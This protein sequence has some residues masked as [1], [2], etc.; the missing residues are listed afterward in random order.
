MDQTKKHIKVSPE[1][2]ANVFS[3]IFY[4][5]FL[6][7]YYFGYKNDIQLKDIYNASKSDHSEM[8]GDKLQMNWE[9]E[10]KKNKPNLKRAIF[11]TFVKPYSL[12]G[13]VLFFQY[14][15]MKATS[16]IIV[17]FIIVVCS[18]G[19]SLS[20]Q[21]VGMRARVAVCSLMYRKVLKLNHKSLGQT[22][23]GQVVN[24][25][26]NDVQRFDLVSLFLHYMW[27]TPINVLVSFYV[28][29]QS[30]GIVAAAAGMGAIILE[31]IPIQAFLSNLQG[32]FRYQ[33]AIKTDRR[34]KLMNEITSGIQVIK[35]YAW[36]KPFEKMV[37]LSRKLE[38]NYIRKSS[39]IFGMI[40]SMA[41]FAER[42]CLYVT[43]MTVVLLGKSIRGDV[44]FSIAQLFNT[45]KLTI[46]INLPWCLSYYADAKVSLARIEK[47]LLLEEVDAEK[48]I[49]SEGEVGEVKLNG[50]TASWK[51]DSIAPTLIDLTFRIEPGTLCCVVGNVGAG[52]SSILQ[53]LLRELTVKSGT[54]TTN[55]RIAFASQEPWLFVSS[56]RNNI[57][58][59]K[60]YDRERYR[61][62]VKVC[63]LIKDFQQ[64]PFGDKTLVGERG[65][66]LS[67]GQRARVNLARAVYSE[68]DIYLFDDP[69]SAVDTKVARHLF[70]ECFI[71]YLSGKTR[72]LVTHQLQFMKQADL[73][74][75]GRIEKIG[76]FDQLS[77]KDLNII[78][79][80]AE[81]NGKNELIKTEGKEKIDEVEIDT[82][83]HDPF[84][85]NIS[86][87]SKFGDETQ[88]KD[89]LIEKGVIKTKTYMAYWKDGGGWFFLLFTLS[90]FII[91]QIASNAADLW[92]TNWT[93][94]EKERIRIFEKNITSS[95]RTFNGTVNHTLDATNLPDVDIKPKEY[96]MWIYTI[97]IFSSVI[98]L[99]L[100][101]FLYYIIC[102]KASKVLHNKM[103]TNVLRAPMRF[104]D[105]NPSGRILSRFS[106]D[107]GAMDE[108][109][110]RS[111]IEAIQ[112]FLLL[113]GILAMVFSVIPWMVIPTIVLGTVFYWFRV[114]YLK[115]AQG[116]KR[117]EGT[118]KA[119]VFSHLSATLCGIPTIRSAN[120]QQMVTKEFDVLQN[121]HT[122]TWFLFLISSVSFGFYL[123]MISITFLA[124]LTYQFVLFNNGQF[125][126]GNIGLV[127]SQSLILTGM[128]Q[129]GV[130]QSA[131][132][133][134][135]MIS[136]ERI[137]QYTKL[138][139]EGPFETVGNKPPR[140]WP[141]KGRITFKNTCLRYAM[142]L[143]PV[144]K[145]IN[146]CIEPS[147][148]VGIV[149]RTGAGKS[150]LISSI[151]RLAPIDG[152][153]C[154]DDVDTSKIGLN[155]L[156]S[157]ISIIP[158]EPVLFSA[159]LRYNLDPF[160]RHSDEDLWNALEYVELKSAFPDLNV[161]ISE[162][163]SNL[164][165]GQRQ[166]IC[167]ARAIV[168]NN[169]VLV[170]DEATANVDPQ[171]DA[172]IQKTI[173]E[174]FKDCTVLTIAHRLN[175]IM[176]SDRV[177]VM[178]AGEV[179]EF[180]QP[181]ILLQNP[182]SFFSKMLK[183][184][185]P[186]MEDSLKRVAKKAY[187]KK[188]TLPIHNEVNKKID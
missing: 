40:S 99:T 13:I 46:C 132:A 136:V 83:K 26:S 122:S 9:K 97:F 141:I 42:L 164:S 162:G 126:S 61:E 67:G 43:V 124:L 127:V 59:G 178:D 93:N 49:T 74:I 175:T 29:Y 39:Y 30:V 113:I 133:A 167:L 27:V 25:M 21:R 50:V 102:M 31:S 165:A 66:S 57:L 142:E 34:V 185:G 16:I 8:W 151:F 75:T 86:L 19:S 176:D 37:T 104:F 114:V 187:L 20:A 10:L 166:L 5:W 33:I 160:E 45:V 109:L 131:D 135:N 48:L 188:N 152:T 18:H 4:W 65:V 110:P 177:L 174:R 70:Q 73:I 156:R 148:K 36:E 41:V 118:T 159:S 69:L 125:L 85:S 62:V 51:L 169:R 14:N 53:L 88:E 58:F 80:E 103:F 84:Q 134:S 128:L 117:L 12:S 146:I 121:Q 54:M 82:K 170:M 47:F 182:E 186:A 171:T 23:I 98:F 44:I 87:V 68:A 81:K 184:S 76:E 72:V 24:L 150:T 179:I 7:F 145:N 181:Y 71:K 155:D 56:V 158:Q 107:M 38:V 1:E 105:T 168:K 112:V 115:T 32:K 79:Q 6:P 15:I 28:M 92:L 77:L 137:M 35:M 157:N 17:A 147:E 119:P 111:L 143:P 180:D 94:V 123:D 3:K 11:Y 173:R 96:Y 89:E 154:I 161:I 90:M 95:N 78:Q 2:K 101:S 138:D 22:A 149:G 64:F 140:D 172:L 163:G 91:A 106:K 60:P 100:R 139:R 108:L 63:S 116:I 129:F 55:G 120:A 153:I 130:R 183:E 144:L 52:K